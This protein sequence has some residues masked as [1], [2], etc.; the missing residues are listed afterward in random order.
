MFALDSNAMTRLNGDPLKLFTPYPSPLSA[1]VDAFSQVFRQDENYYAFPPYCLLSS[2]IKFIIEE[3]IN[4][5]I[6]F[7]QFLP[8]PNWFTLVLRYARCITVVGFKGDKGVLM[9]PSRKGYISDKYGLAFNML[10]A[11][12]VSTRDSKIPVPFDRKFNN[13]KSSKFKPVIFVGDSM[14]KFL[15]NHSDDVNIVSIGWVRILDVIEV[16]E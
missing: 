7:P 13:A 4:C 15:K 10:A 12:F 9:F 2:V 6:L 14:I 11:R 8:V 1:G 3:Q 5:T 16:I